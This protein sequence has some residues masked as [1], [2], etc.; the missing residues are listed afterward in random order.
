MTWVKYSVN[1][2]LALSPPQHRPYGCAIDLLPG[3]PLPSSRLF[4]LSRPEREKMEK[5]IHDSL[6]AGIIRPSSS[7]VGAGFL[8]VSKKDRTLRPCIDYQD[9]KTIT[10]K[11]K[12]PLP[13]I[14]SAFE[15]IQQATILFKTRPEECLP[16]D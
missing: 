11:N 8:F 10:V 13:L 7:P 1:S 16:P 5:Y 12:C 15:P 2:S 3:A 4:N 14:N 9:L 6:A